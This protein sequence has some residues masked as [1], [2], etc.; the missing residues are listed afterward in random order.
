MRENDIILINPTETSEGLKP[1]RM[2]TDFSRFAHLFHQ[3]GTDCKLMFEIMIFI[4]H[5][6]QY[7]I[8]L[9]NNKINKFIILILMIFF[10]LHLYN[11]SHKNN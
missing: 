10:Y 11:T 7:D 2:E 6:Y 4:N 1:V 8:N 9:F 3:F 5:E